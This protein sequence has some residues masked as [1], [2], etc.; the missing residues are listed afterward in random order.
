LHVDIRSQPSHRRN[1][2]EGPCE[3]SQKQTIIVDVRVEVQG[4]LRIAVIA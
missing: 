2:Q 1:I 4:T 3:M